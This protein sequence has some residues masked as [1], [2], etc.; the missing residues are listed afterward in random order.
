V[1]FGIF[2]LSLKI[3]HTFISLKKGECSK[4]TSN[5]IGSLF[6]EEIQCQRSSSIACNNRFAQL[7]YKINDLVS[8]VIVLQLMLEFML[9]AFCFESICACA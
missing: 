3:C 9:K 7:L 4:G 2:Q 5:Y 1:N 8:T 6:W